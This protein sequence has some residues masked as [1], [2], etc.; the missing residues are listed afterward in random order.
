MKKTVFCFG[1][2]LYTYTSAKSLTPITTTPINV[3]AKAHI[4]GLRSD[5]GF[6]PYRDKQGFLLI[7]QTQPLR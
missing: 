7:K 3:M 4:M 5:L 1:L 6:M 2:A